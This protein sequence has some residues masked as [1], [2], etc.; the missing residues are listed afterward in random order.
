MIEQVISALKATEQKE[1]AERLQRL[2]DSAISA[3]QCG[4]EKQYSS[5]VWNTNTL[6]ISKVSEL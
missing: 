5:S 3:Y 4:N 2:Y 6:A 1:S